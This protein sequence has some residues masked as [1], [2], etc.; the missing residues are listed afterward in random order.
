MSEAPHSAAVL[1]EMRDTWWS[2]DFLKLMIARLDLASY[3]RVADLGCG[4]GHWGQRLLPLLADAATIS[5]VDQEPAWVAAATA[6]ATEL[7]L[8]E[9]CS[10]RTATV[11]ALPFADAAFD[12]VTCQTVLM[13]VA[14]PTRALREMLRIL[15]PGGRLLLVEPNNVAHQFTA[16]SVNRL[17]TPQELGDLLALFTSCSRGRARL[18]R[19]DDCVGDRLPLLLAE[20]GAENLV[21]FQNE[22]TNIIVP[23]YSDTVRA[24]LQEQL[25][26]AEAGFWLWDQADARALYEAGDG[27]PELFERYYDVFTRRTELFAQQVRDETYATTNG[28]LHYVIS[29]TRPA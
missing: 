23:P 5:G 14:D 18:G 20:L 27:D 2:T 16:D 22:R 13:H 7:G 1:T 10:Y 26:Y 4:K 15:R 8:A 24:Q 25:G 29:A 17:L 21:A 9:R 3:C 28:S 19:G 11:D 12:L 6:R